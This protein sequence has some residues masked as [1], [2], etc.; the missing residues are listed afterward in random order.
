[1]GSETLLFPRPQFFEGARLNF[2]ENLLYP[3]SSPNEDTVAIIGATEE[4]SVDPLD[5]ILDLRDEFEKKG[6]C[7]LVHAD[8][9]WGGYFASMVRDKPLNVLTSVIRGDEIH[10]ADA[11]RVRSGDFNHPDPDPE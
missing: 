6:L 11:L 1:M 4:G 3:A 7:F 10:L 9:A 2:A 5:E 8:A